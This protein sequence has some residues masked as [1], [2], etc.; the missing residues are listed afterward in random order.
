MSNRVYTYSDITQLIDAPYYDEIRSCPNIAI[1]NYVVEALEE[2][3]HKNGSQN[4]KKSQTPSLADVTKSFTYLLQSLFPVWG[5]DAF[6]FR[7]GVIINKVF[8]EKIAAARNNAE[9]EWLWGCKKNIFVAI[10]NII[11]LEEANVRPEDMTATDRDMKLFVELWRALEREPEECDNTNHN[12]MTIADFRQRRAYLSETK[13]F[14]KIIKFHNE[15]KEVI[16]HGFQY[17]TPMQKFVYDCFCKAGYQVHALIQSDARY[18]YAN[19]IWDNLYNEQNGYVPKEQWCKPRFYSNVNPLGK[20]Y[21]GDGKVSLNNVKLIK[22]KDSVEFITDVDRIIKEGYRMYSA[23]GAS[24]NN[25]LR[26]YYPEYFSDRNFL[27]YPIGQFVSIIHDAWDENRQ[28]AIIK[29]NDLRRCFATGWLSSHGKS[30]IKYT[31]DLE[32][33]LGYFAGCETVAEWNARIITFKAAYDNAVDMLEFEEGKDENLLRFFSTYSLENYRITDVMNIIRSFVQIVD[34]L[35]AKEEQVSIQKH[36]EKLDSLIRYTDNLPE[37]LLRVE[38]TKITEFFAALEN[39]GTV[40][41]MCHPGDIAA[42]LSVYLNQLKDNN[43]EDDR[44]NSS[45]VYEMLQLTAAPVKAKGKVHICLSDINKMPGAGRQLTWPLDEK[46]LIA[47]RD[48]KSD[49][50]IDAWLNGI[51]VNALSNRQYMYSA[52]QNNYVEISWIEKQG[53]KILAPSPYITLLERFS[54]VIISDSE[55]KQ[56]GVE[57]VAGIRA[58]MHLDKQFDI[59]NGSHTDD[60]KFEYAACPMRY[61]YGYVLGDSTNYKNEYQIHR[62]M[63]RLIQ[64][65]YIVL[66]KKY[67]IEE[68]AENVFE[69][70]PFV[71]KGEKRQIL[72]DAINN[73][74]D[75]EN[76][77]NIN[78]KWYL[79]V[80]DKDA[81]KYAMENYMHNTR[82]RLTFDNGFKN[83]VHNCEICPHCSYCR[84]SMFGV[85]YKVGT[86]D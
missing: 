49:T 76:D 75:I 71:R 23:D 3:E 17:F 82:E 2:K 83:N 44:K 7:C 61:V 53:D 45:L 57:E 43:K 8:R 28:C 74:T 6:K 26:D 56:I 30:S 25:M 41:Y 39:F 9:A 84:R 70:F 14:E 66:D 5:T 64:I 55:V 40:D 47:I 35:F 79:S 62:A 81:Y 68:V 18:P 73:K 36:I 11:K 51:K 52:L 22:Y 59:N 10:D 60:E 31:A 85:D 58:H 34:K 63:V 86:N 46:E 77:E 38:K 12:I 69:L 32:C 27:A 80:P 20:I 4:E 19:E 1:S 72:D 42:I 21:N 50:Y 29:P 37:G 78:Y 16:F 67:P 54:D 33:I 15:P 48:R 65:L 13:N 24:A